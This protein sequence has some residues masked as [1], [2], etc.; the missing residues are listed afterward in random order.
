MKFEDTGLWNL[1]VVENKQYK[2]FLSKS[3]ILSKYREE[4]VR[5]A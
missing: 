1:P 5:S 3:N 2:G 4:Q